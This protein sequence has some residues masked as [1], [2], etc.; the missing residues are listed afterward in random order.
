MSEPLFYDDYKRFRSYS[1]YLKERFGRK[2]YKVPLNAGFSCPNRDGTKGRGGCIYCSGALSGEFAG[3]PG[4][5]IRK[6]YEAVRSSLYKKWSGGACIPYFQAGSNT[7]ADTS[8]LRALYKAALSLPDA[9]GLSIATRADCIDGEKADMLA[10]LAEGT[11]L[12]V[13]LGLQT[14]HDKTAAAINRCHS[15][16]DFLKGFELLKSRGINVCVHIINGLPGETEEMMR[17]TARAV[18]ELGAHEIKIHMLHILRGTAAEE[19]YRRGGWELMEL[20]GYVSLVCD[21]I[22]LLPDSVLIGRLTG[23]GAKEELVA[24]LWT[25]D[26]RRVLNGIDKELRRRNTYQGRAFSEVRS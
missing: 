14:I 24:P 2:V 16:E 18:G 12:T 19:L 22:E 17:E 4:E 13:E 25:R 8:A 26:K 10:E 9:V 7:Y 11:Y 1:G 20:E 3:D 5:S 15:Y 21:Q 23:D 6:Q